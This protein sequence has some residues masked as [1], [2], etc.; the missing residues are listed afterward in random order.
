MLIRMADEVIFRVLGDEAVILN[1]ATSRYFGL[2][3]V[4]TRLW[5]LI[6]EHG[7]EEK[8]IQAFLAEYEVEEKQLRQDLDDLIQQLRQKGLVQSDT[9][10]TSQAV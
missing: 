2:N 6:A 7:S 9:Q 10:E 8:V 4:G 1:L 3:S 5:Q